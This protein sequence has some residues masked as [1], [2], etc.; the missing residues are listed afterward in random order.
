MSIYLS[1]YLYGTIIIIIFWYWFILIIT[2]SLGTLR[3]IYMEYNYQ[4][5]FPLLCYH[6]PLLFSLIISSF[7]YG[8]LISTVISTNWYPMAWIYIYNW[9]LDV[10]HLDFAWHL[11]KGA[12]LGQIA[13][14]SFPRLN[15]LCPFIYLSYLSYL[16]I[17]LSL[18]FNLSI[19]ISSSLLYPYYFSIGYY[20]LSVFTFSLPLL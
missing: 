3:N 5:L 9:D 13:V 12:L 4:F 6:W 1:V 11:C 15:L 20:I 7:I 18:P 2:S 10:T 19:F 17:H 16:S 8:G 14:S